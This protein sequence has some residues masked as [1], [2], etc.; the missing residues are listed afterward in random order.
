[1]RERPVSR[2]RSARGRLRLGLVATR[3]S[4]SVSLMVRTRATRIPSEA[5]SEHR[6]DGPEERMKEDDGREPDE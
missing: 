3:T 2:C 1:M 4:S 5:T 6:V